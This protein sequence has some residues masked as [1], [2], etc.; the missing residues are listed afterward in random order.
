MAEEKIEQAGGS[1][2]S[3]EDV[4]L[5]MMKFIAVTTNY[6]KGAPVTGFSKGAASRT[7]EEHAD[8]LIELFKKCR[9]AIG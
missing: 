4:A 8:S 5:D 7:P 1:G 3:K 9:E 6:G 2:R